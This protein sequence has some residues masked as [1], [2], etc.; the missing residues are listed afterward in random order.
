M[1]TAEQVLAFEGARLNQGGDET[2]NW[3]PLSRGTAWCMAFQS[4]ALTE[5]GIPTRY[6]W[7]SAFFDAYRRQG[8]NSY[9]IRSALPG[10]LVA[11]EWGS[12]PGG[13]DHVAMIIG[14][15]ESGAWTR[16]GNVN[17]SRVKDLWFPF[18]GGGM[19]EIAR[20]AYDSTPTPGPG[21]APIETKDEAM[22]HFKNVDGRDEYI[23][24]TAGGQV[25]GCWSTT[26]TGPIGPWVELRGG[27]AGSNLVAEQTSDGR[28]C[29]T[30]AAVGELWGSW[31]TTPGSGP[32]CDWFKVND[33]RKFFAG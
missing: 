10:D 9:D 27:I 13:Y 25:V 8:R 19:A 28:L 33:L 12:T 30:L 7:V 6:A 2:W 1:T 22:F 20:P 14:L 15:T 4:M 21:P 5:C 18:N 32:W 3:Y 29:V 31:Q 24:L 23:A 17:G 11:F 16:N 26:P